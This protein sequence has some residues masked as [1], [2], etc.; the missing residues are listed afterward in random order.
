MESI[1]QP[2]GIKEIAKM[3][4]V[5]IATVDRVIHNRPGVA[6]KTKARI[7]AIIKEFNYR[8]NIL[9]RR[10]ATRKT[11]RFASFIP[12]VT[13]ET[14]FWE[15]PLEGVENAAKVL[16]QYGI[17]LDKYFFDESDRQSFIQTAGLILKKGYDGVLMAPSFVVESAAFTESLDE[18]NI[19]YVF[20]NSDIPDKQSLSYIGPDLFQSGYLAAHLISF[21]VRE[22]DEILLLNISRERINHHVLRKE[23]GFR[24][25]LADHHIVNQITKF[26]IHQTE[27]DS[28]SSRLETCDFERYKVIFVTNS[29]VSSVARYLKEIGKTNMLLI[30]Y[31]FLE[32]NVNYLKQNVIDFL[33]CQKPQEQAY[34][35]LMALYDNMVHYIIPEKVQF[36]PIDIITKENYM[37]YRN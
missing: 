26:D 17:K 1:D 25:Y 12:R 29:R 31:D 35:G 8:P 36:M 32:Q 13:A 14:N 6:E 21:L 9:A 10:L 23:E 37:F 15:A 2:F 22:R 33:I 27:Y 24:Q 34:K 4:K 30:G 28:V 5:S 18:L 20:I 16:G 3:A 7:N 19:P 11:V